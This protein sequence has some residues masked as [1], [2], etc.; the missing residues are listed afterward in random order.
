MRCFLQNHGGA[1][2]WIYTV[3]YCRQYACTRTQRMHTR[4][5]RVHSCTRACGTHKAA[6]VSISPVRALVGVACSD[7]EVSQTELFPSAQSSEHRCPDD[8]ADSQMPS[9]IMLMRMPS[10]VK[11]V[12]LQKKGNDSPKPST[13]SCGMAWYKKFN[14]KVQRKTN[15][16]F[17]KLTM[18]S[19]FSSILK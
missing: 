18:F 10:F 17:E 5:V 16:A 15:P 11:K 6:R 13:P 14:Q 9:W 4:L 19:K 7:D 8:D 3:P 12:A 2:A 1:H